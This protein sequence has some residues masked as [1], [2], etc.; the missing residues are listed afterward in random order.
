MGRGGQLSNL[1]RR[2]PDRLRFLPL[3]QRQIDADNIGFLAENSIEDRLASPHLE[4]LARNLVA[5][6]EESGMKKPEFAESARSSR[7]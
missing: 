3:C 2:I 6:L 7:S 1:L 5:H 4:R